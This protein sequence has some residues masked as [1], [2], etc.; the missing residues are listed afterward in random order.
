MLS[1]SLQITNI[2][3]AKYQQVER[4]YLQKFAEVKAESG[5]LSKMMDA[6]VVFCL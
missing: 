3:S 2:V 4:F 1:G 6:K 5:S